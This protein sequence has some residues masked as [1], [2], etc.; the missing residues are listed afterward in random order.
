MLWIFHFFKWGNTGVVNNISA[1]GSPIKGNSI[2]SLN[3]SV[4]IAGNLWYPFF[5][6]T[7][8]LC[9]Y[10]ATVTQSCFH[11]QLLSYSGSTMLFRIKFFSPKCQLHLF[12]FKHKI[13]F[14]SLGKPSTQ[15]IF[16]VT[17]FVISSISQLNVFSADSSFI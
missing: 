16:L 5:C 10:S 2:I 1:S 7:G 3:S 6:I 8:S 9:C 12:V 11:V 4:P 13:S 14:G 15:I 17:H